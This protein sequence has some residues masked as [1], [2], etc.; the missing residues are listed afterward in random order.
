MYLWATQRAATA[1]TGAFTYF[2]DHTL[3]GRDAAR[4][5]AFHTSD[6]PYVMNT[7]G[8]SNRPF[9]AA[10]QQ[11][12]DRLSTYGPT[13]SRPATPTRQAYHSGPP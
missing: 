10:D 8:M 11:I 5:A 13:S 2:W 6:V 3:P 7:L 12:A 4:Y 1:R 9:T